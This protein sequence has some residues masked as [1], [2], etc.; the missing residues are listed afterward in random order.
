MLGTQKTRFGLLNT[1]FIGLIGLIYCL[2][3][4]KRFLRCQF[5]K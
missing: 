3:L 4:M 2:P 5:L 1:D